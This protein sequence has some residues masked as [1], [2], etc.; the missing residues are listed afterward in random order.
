MTLSVAGRANANPSVAAS[1]RF[2]LITWSASSDA[3]TDV[4]AAISRDGGRTFGQ[5]AR[6]S[7]G[8]GGVR[9]SGEQPPRAAIVSRSGAD[10]AIVVAWTAKGSDGTRLLTARS[11]DGGKSFGAATNIPG[12]VASGNRGWE[13][14]AV[15]RSG[16]VSIVWLDH[17]D[18][19][20]A[21]TDG[22]PMMH[23]GQQHTGHAAHT[24]GVARAQL[25]KLYFAALNGSANATA[26][27]G[28]VCYC[29][30]TAI[31]TAS[32]GSIYA[33]WRHVYAGNVRDIA[34]TMSR[35]GG[36][37]F[38]APVRVS[39]DKWALDGCPEN[40]PA[41][42]VDA[43]SRVHIVWPTLDQSGNADATTLALFYATA[44]DGRRFS[45]RQRIQTE[46]VPRHAQLAAG[47][48]GGF[49]LAWDEQANAT[50]RVIAAP[51]TVSGDSLQLDRR[52]VL[53]D[54][55][56]A[57]YPATAAADDGYVVAWTSG[58]A[59]TS[60]IRVERVGD[61]RGGSQ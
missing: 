53:G 27:T 42:A 51:A 26:I 21:S 54:G 29:C 24:D 1:G 18:A 30:K 17:R 15:D 52:I 6:V 16:T 7:D 57:E 59:G 39:E 5:P 32:D 50:R 45:P 38:A 9:V 61:A 28:G 44:L 23:D 22:A 49:L 20:K 34:F 12:S 43:N 3:G 19:T 58:A 14:I 37:S 2:V 13:A 10:P 41:M 36:R 4:Y 25:S 56:R 47:A 46:G 8:S 35:D 60:V 55:E 48:G 40:G 11:D 31:A 33:A